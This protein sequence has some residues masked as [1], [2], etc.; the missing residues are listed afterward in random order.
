ML[1][2]RE[3]TNPAK[4]Y[5]SRVAEA[6]PRLETLVAAGSMRDRTGPCTDADAALRELDM[7][8][9]EVG[10]ACADMDPVVAATLDEGLRAVR[11]CVA[12]TPEPR[13]CADAAR[14][15]TRLESRLRLPS[16]AGGI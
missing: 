7:I 8:A 5:E 3:L 10:P 9:S 11:E 14:A 2:Q 1:L 12:C 13:G 16:Y 6:V 15:L 4:T